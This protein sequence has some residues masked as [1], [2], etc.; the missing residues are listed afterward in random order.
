MSTAKWQNIAGSKKIF[1]WEGRC[2]KRPKWHQNGQ[3]SKRSI[4]ITLALWWEEWLAELLIWEEDT[5]LVLTSSRK[6][7]GFFP[8]KFVNRLIDAWWQKVL[9]KFI[10]SK[11]AKKIDKIFTIDLTFTIHNVKSMLMILSN[12]VA[13][14]DNINFTA[15]E[16][17]HAAHWSSGGLER[18]EI[19]ND[20]YLL[21]RNPF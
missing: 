6:E 19:I 4:W 17:S 14:L 21:I 8:N 9:L 3:I 15:S 12:F 11:N 13:F 2:S 16:L 7:F 18:V 10:F 1:S 20:I 5:D